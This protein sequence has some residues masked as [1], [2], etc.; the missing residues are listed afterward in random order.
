MKI[1]VFGE[2]K[3]LIELANSLNE[4]RRHGP[5]RPRKS[6]SLSDVARKNRQGI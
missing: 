2:E 1:Y 4:K 3:G 5:H 6:E